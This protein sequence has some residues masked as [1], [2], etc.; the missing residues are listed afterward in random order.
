MPARKALAVDSGV[1]FSES[2][3]SAKNEFKAKSESILDQR[4]EMIDEEIPRMICIL[5]Y[6]TLDSWGSCSALYDLAPTAIKVL[7]Y[8]SN[9]YTTSFSCLVV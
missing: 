7:A 1:E 4:D 9:Q 5:S 8:A 2:G 6:T 3:I